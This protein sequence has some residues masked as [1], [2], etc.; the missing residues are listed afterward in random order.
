MDLAYILM[1]AL[2]WYI[3]LTII[4]TP[5]ATRPK[6]K[7]QL[8][9]KV[10][11][12]MKA[13]IRWEQLRQKSFSLMDY[14]NKDDIDALMYTTMADEAGQYTFDAFRHILSNEKFVSKIIM[15]LENQTKVLNQFQAK[16]DPEQNKPD[17]WEPGLISDLLAT[18]IL[19]GLDARYVL[20]EMSLA[21]LPL[22]IRAYENKKKEDME[23]SRLWTYFT[24]LPHIDAKKLKNG[25]K[26]LITFPWE[27]EAAIKQS[28]EELTASLNEFEQRMNTKKTDYYGG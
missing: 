1:L 15:A 11:L 2:F 7:S 4:L 14:E 18:L 23:N 17:D 13:I 24:M 10:V 16:V 20:E 22:Y 28:E 26:D 3:T 12:N 5:S 8:G 9:T 25:A 6:K 19:S 27:Q 21:D